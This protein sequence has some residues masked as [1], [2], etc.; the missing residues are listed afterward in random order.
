MWGERVGCCAEGEEA[1]MVW[2]CVEERQGLDL[3]KDSA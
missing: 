1:G 3:G 2:A